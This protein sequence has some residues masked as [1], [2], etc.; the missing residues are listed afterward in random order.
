MA[1]QKQTF[2]VAFDVEA[3]GPSLNHPVVSVGCCYGTHPLNFTK[4]RWTFDFDET[5]FESKCKNEFWDKNVSLLQMFKLENKH[6]WSDV[7]EFLMDLEK[8]Y[9]KSHHSWV[10]VSD[11]PAYDLEKID[12]HLHMMCSRL[13]VRYSSD[14]SYRWVS[15]PSEQSRYFPD[16][17][18]LKEYVNQHAKHTHLPDEDAEKML[19]EQ[20]YMDSWKC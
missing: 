6:T 9:P 4:K 15:D 14:G 5:K 18:A 10:I 12:Y 7:N 1:A 19:Y 17:T 11:N 8:K 20:F 16:K 2:Y 3:G 13:P